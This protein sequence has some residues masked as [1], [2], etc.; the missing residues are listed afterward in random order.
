MKVDM[1]MCLGAMVLSSSYPLFYS[2]L[3]TR[4]FDN[5]VIP[6]AKKLKE[7]QVFGAASDECLNYAIS[8]RS[9]WKEKG[10]QVVAEFIA[11]VISTE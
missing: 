1:C 2:F 7:C 5:Y 10:E 11:S 8:N 4:F 3:V 6:L 9:E